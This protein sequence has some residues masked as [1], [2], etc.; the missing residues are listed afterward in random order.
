MADGTCDE[1]GLCPFGSDATD[2]MTACAQTPEPA[3]LW[4]ACKYLQDGLPDYESVPE[5]VKAAGSE[6][7][8]GATGS[9]MGQVWSAD[10][11]GQE[12]AISRNFVV[13]VPKA[14]RPEHPAPILIY[15][16]GFVDAVHQDGYHDMRRLSEMNGAIVIDVE[17]RHRDW[18]YR[19]YRQGWYTYVQAF[20]GD[21]TK[22][23]DRDYLVKVIREV[24]SLYNVDRT[25]IFVTG[26]SRGGAISIIWAFLLPD[27]VAGFVSQAG[28]LT[29]A[30]NNFTVFIEAYAANGGR[31]MA[32]VFVAGAQ[33]DN[34]PP[35][36]TT[37]GVELLESLGWRDADML[38]DWQLDGVG[39]QWQPQLS[40]QWWEFLNSHPLPLEEVR[41]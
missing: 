26:T 25:R 9:W 39:H 8:G 29:N 22:N 38:R 21:W 13:H 24:E 40:G 37:R 18:G 16:G 7:S 10:E 1:P 11:R 2:C 20:S 35:S 23:P 15:G 41:R 6:G 27:Y 17:Q 34:V 32:A 36:E 19:G 5:A 3:H 30:V 31:K 4:G 28:F 12:K 14:Y 33:D